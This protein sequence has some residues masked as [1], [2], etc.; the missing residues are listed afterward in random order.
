MISFAN[1][2]IILNVLKTTNNVKIY[3]LLSYLSTKKAYLY[4][5]L[6]LMVMPMVQ[7]GPVGMGVC[8]WFMIM[9]MCMT[10]I[11]VIFIMFVPMMFLIVRMCMFMIYLFMCMIMAVLIFE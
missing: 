2:I 1:Y 3:F 4:G 9:L 8:L 5:L 11:P 6:F 10:V 7:I